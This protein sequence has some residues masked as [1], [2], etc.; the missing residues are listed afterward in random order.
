MQPVAEFQI[1]LLERRTAG[2][3]AATVEVDAHGI[4]TLSAVIARGQPIEKQAVPIG[5]HCRIDQRHRRARHV[6]RR[7]AERQA[8]R[9]RN[10]DAAADHEVLTAIG[11]ERAEILIESRIAENLVIVLVRL[12]GLGIPARVAD[13]VRYAC[14]PAAAVPLLEREV[15][16]IELR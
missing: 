3:V 12:I 4:H 11:V 9:V 2:A 8:V 7:A 13:C 10:L 15:H 5:V 1:G 16:A 14:G 6:A